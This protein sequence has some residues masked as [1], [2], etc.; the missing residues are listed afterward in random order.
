MI[1]GNAPEALPAPETAADT[2]WDSFDLGDN[3]H[4][5]TYYTDEIPE[6]VIKPRKA[7]GRRGMEGVFQLVSSRN[8]RDITR[9][10]DWMADQPFQIWN[11]KDMERNGGQQRY[12]GALEDYDN[13]GLPI[14]YVVRRGNPRG[15][16]VSV[17]GYTTKKSDFPWRYAF[18]N[19]YPTKDLRK[20]KKISDT[21]YDMYGPQ[22]AND[23]MTVTSYKLDPETDRRTQ[24][25]K[26]AGYTMPVPKDLSAYQAFSQFLVYP[27]ISEVILEF[28]GGDTDRAKAI[29]KRIAV[30]SGK[31]PGFASV[32]CS[33][34]YEGFIT[35]EIEKLLREKGLFDQYLNKYVETKR[36]NKPGFTFNRD[37]EKDFKA[38]YT[39]LKSR[40][41]Y[42]EAA[43]K[44]TAT[45]V[46]RD[47]VESTKGV[48]KNIIKPN[49]QR[50]AA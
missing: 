11:K 1:D 28:A 37:D 3:T 29:R 34:L 45:Y 42:K 49:L 7:R 20:G 17:N 38:F 43:K 40:K 16:V 30:N 27:A 39:W 50:L 19:Q 13:D 9:K 2:P 14:E 32:I 47:K 22:Y 18:Y 8:A 24:A 4:G 10:G 48:I 46:S 25:L 5:A 23:N 6:D 31:G 21:V 15:P 35:E 44:L 12:W 41:E 36:R 33:D 26:K